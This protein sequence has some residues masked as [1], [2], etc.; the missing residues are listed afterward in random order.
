MLIVESEQ[1]VCQE[2]KSKQV[3]GRQ[4]AEGQGQATSVLRAESKLTVCQEPAEGREAAIC[5]QRVD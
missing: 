2:F 4:Q 1:V 5:L 3:V